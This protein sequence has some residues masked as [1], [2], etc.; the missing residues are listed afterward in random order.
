LAQLAIDMSEIAIRK[1]GAS[2]Q[3]KKAISEH[4]Q[5]HAPCFSTVVLDINTFV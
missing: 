3:S 1:L 2:A 4:A 5:E